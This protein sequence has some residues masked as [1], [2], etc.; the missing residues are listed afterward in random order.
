MTNVMTKNRDIGTISD[1]DA[2]MDAKDGSYKEASLFIFKSTIHTTHPS[3]SELH[4]TNSYNL[5]N[6]DSINFLSS[7]HPS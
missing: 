3:S 4:L 2:D 7:W 5:F 1:M 6:K